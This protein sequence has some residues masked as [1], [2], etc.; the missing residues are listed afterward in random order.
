MHRYQIWGIWKFSGATLCFSVF[1]PVNFF[2]SFYNNVQ[3]F[4]SC[5]R[6][7]S[8]V[9]DAPISNL[10]YLK[11]FS[12]WLPANLPYCII[13][14]QY[15]VL[16]RKLARFWWLKKHFL[17]EHDRRIKVN[18]NSLQKCCQKIWCLTRY[19]KH[20]QNGTQLWKI[21]SKGVTYI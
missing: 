4:L 9:N 3:H 7:S 16:V 11:V 17:D 2:G 1:F 20:W 6:I 10:M 14:I 21:E 18:V 15:S 8:K 19:Q 5:L 12:P 13:H